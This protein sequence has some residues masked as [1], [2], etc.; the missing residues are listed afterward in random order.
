MDTPKTYLIARVSNEEQR[1]ALE[2]QKLRLTQYADRLHLDYTY[3]QFDESAFKGDR[4]QFGELVAKVVAEKRLCYIVFDKIDRLSRDV[5]HSLVDQLKQLANKG[6]IELHFPSEG[7][8]VKQNSPAMDWFRLDLGLSLAA[9]YSRSTH[10]NVQ[11]RFEHMAVAGK[12]SGLSALGYLNGRRGTAERPIKT[13]E[14]DPDRAHHILTVFE[15]RAEGM[16]FLEIAKLVNKAGLRSRKGCKMN[17]SS[18][19]RIISNP[20]YYG[21][22]RYLGELYDHD[23]PRLIDYKLFYKCQRVGKIRKLNPTNYNS[24]SFTLKGMA[25][26]AMCSCTVSSYKVK[27]NVYLKYSGAKGKCGNVCSAQK[28]FMPNIIKIL[29]NIAVPEEV[30]PQ[31]VAEL[32]KKHG[33]QQDYVEQNIGAARREY[34]KVT[35]RLKKLTYERLDGNIPTDLYTSM[36]EELTARQ[37]ELNQQIEATTESNQDFLITASYLLDLC[38][39]AVLLFNSAPEDLQQKLLKTVLSNLVMDKKM[40]SYDVQEPF[41]TIIEAK[42]KALSGQNSDIWCG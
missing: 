1:V 11:R 18:I 35:A 31:V 13:I 32:R 14:L 30:L 38:Q 12:R 41:K 29:E 23:Y 42:K 5:S 36:V 8:V 15:K 26:C 34:D 22:L 9:N 24:M 37:Q 3:Y 20:F 21:K 16:S 25:K 19:E 6:K 10:D 40:L 2:A 17:K 7:L 28:L 4:R 27:N 33:R 39:R